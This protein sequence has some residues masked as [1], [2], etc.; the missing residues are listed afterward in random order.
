[1]IEES[2]EVVRVDKMTLWVSVN[3]K[4]A[5]ASCSASQGCGQKKILDW[6]PTKQVEVEVGNPR[7]LIVSPGQQVTLGLHEGALV[8]ASLLLYMLPLAGLIIFAL[9]ANI[10]Q[11]S[12]LF[13]III[14]ILGLITGFVV[15][16]VIVVREL[17]FGDFEPQLLRVH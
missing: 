13:Q 15:T 9:F 16:R 7:Q 10:L 3:R 5:C 1:M 14:A 12:E 8:R 17:A 11:F 6:L 2:A 4:S